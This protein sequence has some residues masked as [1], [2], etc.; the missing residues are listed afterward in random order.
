MQE[1]EKRR[2]Q[3]QLQEQ[4]QR[5]RNLLPFPPRALWHGPGVSHSV[6]TAAAAGRRLAQQRMRL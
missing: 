3:E 5:G 4:L 2:R 1:E 6:G